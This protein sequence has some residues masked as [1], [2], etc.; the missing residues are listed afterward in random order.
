VK[1]EVTAET[2]EKA[3]RRARRDFIYE[4]TLSELCIELVKL[5]ARAWRSL[6][7]HLLSQTR[8]A[9]HTGVREGQRAQD[10]HPLRRPRRSRRAC[11]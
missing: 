8:L 9:T 1:L 6:F 11:S 4:H 3:A 7:I 2:L 10:L 5:Q